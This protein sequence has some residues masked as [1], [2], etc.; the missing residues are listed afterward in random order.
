M[1]ISALSPPL[2]KAAYAIIVTFKKI[3]DA[4]SLPYTLYSMRRSTTMRTRTLKE[5]QRYQRW[6]RR[7]KY[8]FACFAWVPAILTLIISIIDALGYLPSTWGKW[9]I[10]VI[11][12]LSFI[13]LWI[14]IPQKDTTTKTLDNINEG[15]KRAKKAEAQHDKNL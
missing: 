7:L 15:I 2:F 5:I 14:A 13:S 9:I 10:V 3:N 11:A 1:L 6:Q 8:W 12:F 4:I